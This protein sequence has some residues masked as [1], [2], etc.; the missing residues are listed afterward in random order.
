[1]AGRPLSDVRSPAVVVV[2]RAAGVHG[3]GVR[4]ELPVDPGDIAPLGGSVGVDVPPPTALHPGDRARRELG[5]PL[6]LSD[7]R[8]RAVG[9][10]PVQ[11]E[12]VREAGHGDAQVSGLPVLPRVLQAEPAEA[13]DR[14]GSEEVGRLESRAQH[15]HVDGSLHAGVVDDA[16]AR[17]RGHRVRDEFGVGFVER[18]VVGRRQDDALAPPR[19]ARCDAAAHL[20]VRDSRLDKRHAACPPLCLTPAGQVERPAALHCLV[21]QPGAVGFLRAGDV[22]VDPALGRAEWPLQLWLDPARFALEDIQRGGLLRDGGHHLGRGGPGSDH[23]NALAGQVDVRLPVRRVER[24]AGKGLQPRPVR[25]A[26]DA[27]QAH[28]GDHRVEVFRA[29]VRGAQLISRLLVKPPDRGHC[30]AQPQVPAQPEPVHDVAGVLEQ[31]R[32]RRVGA[33]P[34]VPH[35]GERVRV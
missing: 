17:H 21:E 30:G 24:G 18:A 5:L 19:V 15:E 32:L 6:K 14:E 10:R 33:R 29:T 8:A 27:E 3:R 28:R 9:V 11:D 35:E 20:L 12:E 31:L 34:V 23:R 16:G 13:A 22:A 2:V 26:R 4:R 7:D 25:D 1:M